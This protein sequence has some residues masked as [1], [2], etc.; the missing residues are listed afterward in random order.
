MNN[1]NEYYDLDESRANL[2][3]LEDFDIS[4]IED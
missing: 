1:D 4:I 2:S 3:R